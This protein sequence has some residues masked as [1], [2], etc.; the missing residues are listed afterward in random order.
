MVR[1]LDSSNDTQKIQMQTAAEEKAAER[2]ME[3]AVVVKVEEGAAAQ[4][5]SP[6]VCS[7]LAPIPPT[8]P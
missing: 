5:A 1:T 4:G 2:E 7:K 3:M 6:E 8:T